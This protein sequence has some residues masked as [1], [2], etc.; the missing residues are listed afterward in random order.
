M[1]LSS[2]LLLSGSALLA[3]FGLTFAGP[4]AANA[5]TEGPSAAAQIAA[6]PYLYFGWGS[7]PNPADVMSATG[8]KAFTLAFV[9]SDGGCNPAWDGTRP[10]DGD[11][12]S[13]IDGIRA[14]GGDVIPSFG[15]WS[16]NKLGEHC[17]DAD[18]LAGAYQKVIDAYNLKAID[19][20]IESTEFENE[21][22]QDRVLQALKIVK[23]K[24]SGISTI[25][26]FGTGTDGP[27]YWGQRLIKRAAELDAGVSVFTI[28]PFDF[29][30]GSGNMGDL[31]V[32]ASEGLH[33]ALKSAFG[34][35]DDETYQMQGISSMNGKTDQSETVTPND[36]TTILDY[37][38]QH[39]LGRFTF[40][41][42]NRDRPCSGGATDSCSGIDQ[43]P[44]EFTKIVA[45]YTG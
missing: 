9:L 3:A 12:K 35:S 15:G 33:A 11:D 18:S 34:A 21:A 13:K 42:V 45:G 24:N 8:V 37:A 29:G 17:Q 28:M 26:T 41:S 14:A 5:T 10:L 44:L 6:A 22:T 38:R 25:L 7:P 32:K 39:H 30:G 36:F 16:G 2:R 20:D 23:A 27:N 1:Q 19:V 4:G 31:T 40:W 43:Q